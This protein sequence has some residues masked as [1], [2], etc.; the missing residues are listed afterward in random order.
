MS[1]KDNK[2]PH[3]SDDEQHAEGT[4]NAAQLEKAQ[5][6]EAKGKG[7]KNNKKNKK[8]GKK[9][10]NNNEDNKHADEDKKEEEEHTD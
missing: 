8:K 10:G 6:E 7:G 1:D 4:A 2:S 5:P 3:A 9:G